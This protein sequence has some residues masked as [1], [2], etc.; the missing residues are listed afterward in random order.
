MARI[1]TVKPEFWTDEKVVE[2]SAFARLLFIGL[3]NFADDEGRMVYSPKRIKMQIFPSDSIECSELLGE[4]RRESLISVYVVDGQE[5]LQINGF[6][7]HQKVD[8]RTTSKIPPPPDIH[9][10]SPRIPP[11]EGI[12]EGIK[13][14]KTQS[15]ASTAEPPPTPKPSPH[16][17]TAERPPPGDFVGLAIELRKAG[18]ACTA[19]HPRVIEWAEKG[20][21]VAMALEAVEV[22]RMR[23]P[24]E[25]V[26]PNYLAPIIAEMLH[27]KPPP[28]PPWWN[29]PEATIAKGEALG[30]RA[31]PG[32]QMAEYRD[33]IREAAKG[34]RAAA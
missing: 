7:K 2:L 33:R 9:A 20:V 22:A 32:E 5:Y 21:T 6:A 16:S 24:G 18:V 11:T 19:S 31:K 14:G 28:E 30:I 17:P 13:E 27:P 10:E 34:Q 4:I 26:S 23:K 15:S 8:K 29:T 1:R 25:P 12:K 3:W